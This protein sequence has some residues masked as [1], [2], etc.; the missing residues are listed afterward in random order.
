MSLK[1][2][3]GVLFGV[4]SRVERLTGVH[5]HAGIS[6]KQTGYSEGK[7]RTP[8]WPHAVAYK[9]RR[10]GDEGIDQVK[11]LYSYCETPR[12]DMT[13]ADNVGSR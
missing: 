6:N 3:E 11:P 10:W 12:I 5:N 9:S 1:N 13:S 4:S 7:I 8:A 2:Y